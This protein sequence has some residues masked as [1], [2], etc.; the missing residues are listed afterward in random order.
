M[1]WTT[2]Q[3]ALEAFGGC[4]RCNATGFDVTGELCTCVCRKVFRVCYHRFKLCLEASTAARTVTIVECHSGVDRHLV[5]FR[6]H[7]DYCAD[8]ANTGRRVLKGY[9]LGIFRFYH[10]LGGSVSLVAKRLGIARPTF[11]RYMEEAEV[12]VG[13]ELAL[14]K[15]YSPYPPHRYMHDGLHS[16][17]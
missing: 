14:M 12:E 11:Y 16:S 13:R 10:L 15:P 2:E 17:R 6:R 4:E 8:F 9:A 5:W 1:D 3:A 7:E